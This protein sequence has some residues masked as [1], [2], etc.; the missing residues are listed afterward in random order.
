MTK[1]QE[2]PYAYRW[3]RL[4]GRK[5]HA[6]RVVKRG[7]MNTVLIEFVDGY[8]VTTSGNALEKR[9][10]MDKRGI[11][12]KYK[13]EKADGSPVDPKAIYFTLRLDTDKHARAAVRAYI[14]S[15]RDEQPKLAQDLE[16]ILREMEKNQPQETPM[17]ADEG[18]KSED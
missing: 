13:I 17:N 8:R 14:E 12:G 10:S 18:G 4:P 15:C 7:K 9:T 5:G 3:R 11:Y 6:C 2:Y 16:R 1:N